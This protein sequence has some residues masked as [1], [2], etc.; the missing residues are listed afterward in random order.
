[1]PILHVEVVDTNVDGVS[2]MILDLA[3]DGHNLRAGLNKFKL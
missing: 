3:L 2:L 1:M